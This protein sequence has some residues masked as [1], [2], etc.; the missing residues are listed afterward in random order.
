MLKSSIKH[1]PFPSFRGVRNS[2]HV[3][4]TIFNMPAN[5]S[6]SIIAHFCPHFNL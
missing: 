6:I 4:A 5:L 3:P 2:H 1:T